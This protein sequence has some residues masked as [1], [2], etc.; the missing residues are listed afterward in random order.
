MIEW[1]IVALV[2]LWLAGM[3]TGHILGGL[4]WVLLVVAGILFLVR[5]T[6]GSRPTL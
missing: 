1:V 2:L 6:R 4:V 5:L 3:V